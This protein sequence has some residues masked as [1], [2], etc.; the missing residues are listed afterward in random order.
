MRDAEELQPAAAIATN[1]KLIA[2][3]III[4]LFNRLIVARR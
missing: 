2:F 4:S 1:T 3:I